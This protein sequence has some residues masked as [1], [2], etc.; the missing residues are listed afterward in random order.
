MSPRRAAAKSIKDKLATDYAIFVDNLVKQSSTF[1]RFK[2]LQNFLELD[3]FSAPG[4]V[5]HHIGESEISVIEFPTGKEPVYHPKVDECDLALNTD[6]SAR[7]LFII[8]NISPRVVRILGGHLEVDPAFFLDY[9]DAIPAE[10]DITKEV[11][12]ARPTLVPIPWYRFQK[13][14]GHLPILNSVKS[15]LD[16]ITLRFVGPREYDK[17]NNREAQERM[18]ADLQKMNV[19]RIAGL[20]VPIARQTG[21]GGCQ[22]NNIAM[23]R[24]CAALWFKEPKDPN[25]PEWTKAIVL[26]DPPFEARSGTGETDYG[27]RLQSAYRSFVRRPLPFEMRKKDTDTRTSYKDSLL[28]AFQHSSY[29]LSELH[30]IFVL[31]SV[32]RIV[33]SEWIATSAYVERDINTLEWRLETTDIGLEVFEKLLEKLFILRRRINKYQA[34]IEDQSQAFKRYLP[35]TWTKTLPPAGR[36]V[37]TGMENDMD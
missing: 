28:H 12:C 35:R 29:P 13:A 3:Q 11:E 16:H 5:T 31:Q 33:V 4:N 10:F 15:D 36:K 23:T 24:H 34:L 14:E 6:K 1:A 22:L 32:A 20:H 9:L 17:P 37:S 7:Q 25:H 18:N 8:E 26:L 2:A 30:P 27:A 19:E 21:A